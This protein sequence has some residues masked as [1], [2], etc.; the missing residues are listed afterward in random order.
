[1]RYWKFWQGWWHSG[2][3]GFEPAQGEDSDKHI[4][5]MAKQKISLKP[6]PPIPF[7]PKPAVECPPEFVEKIR[8][9]GAE[10]S[11]LG[12]VESM[13]PEQAAIALWR[14]AQGHP[15]RKIAVETGLDRETIKQLQFRQADIL[16]LYRK[17]FA[18]A[19]SRAASTYTDLL[20]DKADRIAADPA[21]LDG[22]SPDRLALTVGIMTDK[23]A[24]LSGMAGVIVEHRKGATVADAAQLIAEARARVAEKIK[25]QA[26]EAEIIVGSA[27]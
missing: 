23:A 21:Q 16:H 10:N 4:I 25:G 19:Y 7:T 11:A 12:S 14:L 5:T 13:R 20:M 1:L 15:I 2:R 9:W 18:D 27:S 24:Q 22:I 17:E 26:I 8:Q 6:A 3:D